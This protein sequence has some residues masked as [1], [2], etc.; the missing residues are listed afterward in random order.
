MHSIKTKEEENVRH[1]GVFAQHAV[2]LLF[3]FDLFFVN[4]MFNL[5]C[6]SKTQP[7]GAT[8]VSSLQRQKETSFCSSISSKNL[9]GL[10]WWNFFSVFHLFVHFEQLSHGWKCKTD[11]TDCGGCSLPVVNIQ[12]FQ[13]SAELHIVIF[14]FAIFFS[15]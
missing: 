11:P 2:H 1:L 14:T 12:L 7:F 13:N 4:M 3:C 5:D 9:I 6:R 10:D 8:S 15:L